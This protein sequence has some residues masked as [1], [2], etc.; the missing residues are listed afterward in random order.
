[1]GVYGLAW[2]PA[3]SLEV[4]WTPGPNF[5]S[6]GLLAP[7]S[8]ICTFLTKPHNLG[9]Y[10]LAWTPAISFEVMGTLKFKFW[11]QGP[12]GAKFKNLHFFH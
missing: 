5:G 7:N 2:T 4:I 10:E 6:K 8:K 3:I 12:F 11:A 9:V 1:M